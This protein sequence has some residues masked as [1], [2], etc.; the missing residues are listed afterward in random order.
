MGTVH[1]FGRRQP[2]PKN[3]QAQS[4]S[5]LARSTRFIGFVLLA[6]FLA[7]AALLSDRWYATARQTP[8]A[9][10][11]Y[12]ELREGNRV[13]QMATPI[14]VTAIDGDSLRSGKEDI[15]LLG[16]DAVE[17]YQTCRDERGREWACGREAHAALRS[18]VGSGQVR[19][20][21]SSRDRFG[22]ALSKCSAGE[23]ADI[24]EAL[25]RAGYAV[26]FMSGD[27]V[28]AEAE[29]RAA[30]RG[31]WRGRFEQ[32]QAWRDRHPRNDGRS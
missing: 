4:R 21:S 1:Y 30:K 15:R 5:A 6:G 11:R 18:I 20:A 8:V 24:S 17:L 13:I 19:C 29:A 14:T 26:N 2:P 12:L 27:Y 9:E 32:P 3:W 28:S 7:S 10:D 16:I 31:I 23:I 22:R 25:V